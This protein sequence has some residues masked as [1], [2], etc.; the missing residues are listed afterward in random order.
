MGFF[1]YRPTQVLIR[2][3]FC[4]MWPFLDP[5]L[6]S[7]ENLRFMCIFLHNIQT[8]ITDCEPISRKGY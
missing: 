1:D 8:C 2:F 7:L 5:L 6:I 4:K 3:L